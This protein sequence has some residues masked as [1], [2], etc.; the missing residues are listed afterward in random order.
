[1]TLCD[2]L[3]REDAQKYN[4]NSNLPTL[5]LLSLVSFLLSRLAELQITIKLPGKGEVCRGDLVGLQDSKTR[6]LS[7]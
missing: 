3:K 1:M 6:G 2:E 5:L 7:V 4:Y